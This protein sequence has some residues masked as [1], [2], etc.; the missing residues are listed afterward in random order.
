[1]SSRRKKINQKK[2]L[3]RMTYPM[4]IDLKPTTAMA[5]E[6]S[7]GLEWRREYN[8]GG[9]EVG[10]ARARDI[11]NRSNL[12]P[13]TIGRMVSYFARHEV[14][15]QGQGFS[16]GEDGYPSAGRIAWALWGGDPGASWARSKY[17]QLNPE[18]ETM[19]TIENK[20]GKVKLNEA[21]TQDSIRRMTEEIGRM[22]GAKASAEGADFGEIM[23]CAENAVDVLDIEINSPGGSVFDGYTIYREIK[24]LRDRGVVVNATITGMAASMASVIAMAADKISI[25]KHGRMMIH[26]ASSGAQGNAESL[27]KTADL[28]DGISDDIAGI[29]AERT[30]IDKEEIREMMKRETWMTARETMANGFVDEVLGEQVDI[31]QASAESPAMKFLDRLTQPSNEEA[32]ERI[33]ALEADITAQAAE[34]QSKLEKA[35]LAL[36]EAAEITAQNIELRIQAELVPTLEA[37]IVELENAAT[38]TAEKIDIA[39][40]QKLAS[41][42]HGEALDLGAKAPTETNAKEL[43]LVA[44]NQLTPSQRM[45]FVKSGGKISN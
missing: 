4:A 14:D 12:S 19:I 2:P 16:P 8:R 30:G 13:E 18:S 7:R 20:A 42:G 43:S 10:V 39:A 38:I 32:L 5:A 1:M 3:K 36:Q 22:F 44:F 25:V 29:Y 35:E 17:K 24:S 37:K 11:S 45:D 28:L 40:A 31:R 9:T 41:M 34:F 26:D 27:R 33:T 6:A 21:V 15:K 23:N